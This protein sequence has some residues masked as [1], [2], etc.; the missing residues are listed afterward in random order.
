MVK[1]FT[2]CLL[3]APLISAFVSMLP[4]VKYRNYLLY[5]NVF[6]I[7]IGFV[8]SIVILQSFLANKTQI[9]QYLLFNWLSIL[10]LN[11][12]I[13]LQ[14]DI[15]ASVMLFLVYTVSW[16]VH[17]YSIGYMQNDAGIMRFFCY[18][19]L[20]TFAMTI[21]VLA[22]NFL[23]LFFGWEGVGL[24][25]YL[26]IGF[27]YTKESAIAAGLKA[28]LVNR[29]SDLAL[30][31]G[32]GILIFM[33]GDFSYNAIFALKEQFDHS[34]LQL[35]LLL[36]FIGAMGKSAQLP[37]HV[38]LPD[39]MEGPTPISALIHAATMVTAGVYLI[40]RL[41]PLYEMAPFVGSIIQII[42]LLTALFLGLIGLVAN[43]IKRIIAYSTLSQLGYMVTIAG[44]GGYSVAIF[45]L[46][47]HGFF[48]AL[49][50]L[51]A[52]QVIVALHHEQDIRKMGGLR[53]KLPFTY[54]AMLVGSLA[55]AGFPGTAGFYSKELILLSLASSNSLIDQISYY[56]LSLGVL[57]TTGY[58]FRL[59]FVVFHGE[60]TTKVHAI[61][62]SMSISL[63]LLIAGSL[64]FGIWFFYKITHGLF[65]AVI[66]DRDLFSR[67]LQ[68]MHGS[69]EVFLH[70]FVTSAFA[71][72]VV[73]LILCYLVYI[74]KKEIPELVSLFWP[75]KL[76]AKGYGFDIL[77]LNILVPIYL[78][79]SKFLWLFVDL[80]FVDSILVNGS[81]G[82]F[83]SSSCLLRYLY[84][85]K[86]V[87]YIFYIICF[88]ALYI[89]VRHTL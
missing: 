19:G 79:L 28:F 43:D 57:I 54:I 63:I 82:L 36:I 30:L 87:Y 4:M 14:V 18:L 20:F 73:G 70:G 2:Y 32:M 74:K 25:S 6:F 58:S 7:G 35:A 34:S 69:F 38:W 9:E 29:V 10:S 45:H 61:P 13:S 80:L 33:A 41:S 39:S 1:E 27:Y 16:V 72:F 68:L 8:A 21:L 86:I 60:G 78:Q 65:S 15:L 17:L 55:L 84:N 11:I 37:L 53:T 67:Q 26:L 23:L 50:F 48:K 49:L 81:S 88:V 22:D 46:L 83:K 44:A 5:A 12:D 3:L 40:C 75:E 42:G 85:G 89:G 51:G 77:Y 56:L 52:G 64:L 71:L 66:V 24:V 31:V 62:R 76:L 59:M 47:T